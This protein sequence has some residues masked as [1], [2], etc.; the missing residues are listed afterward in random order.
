VREM[1]VAL[2]IELI[3]FAFDRAPRKERF[4]YLL[5]AIIFCPILLREGAGRKRNNESAPSSQA[6]DDVYPLF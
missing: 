2:L 1:K 6:G 3:R 4:R 5:L